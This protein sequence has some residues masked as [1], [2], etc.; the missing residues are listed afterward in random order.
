MNGN[1]FE[2]N[3]ATCAANGF[4]TKLLYLAVGGGIGATLA[5]LFAP[6]P[7]RELRADIADAATNGYDRVR[8][9]A[10]QVKE[11]G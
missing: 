5:L 7:G 11:Q 6:K 10:G 9:T 2:N 3:R 1:N 4:G 8:E